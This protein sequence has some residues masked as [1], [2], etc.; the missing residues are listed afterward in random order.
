MD[1][2]RN[3]IVDIFHHDEDDGPYVDVYNYNIKRKYDIEPRLN[4]CAISLI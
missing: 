3:V 2:Y 4:V 1:G